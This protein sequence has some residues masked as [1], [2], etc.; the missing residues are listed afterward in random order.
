MITLKLSSLPKVFF[1]LGQT[2]SVSLL[3]PQLYLLSCVTLFDV[4][5]SWKRIPNKKLKVCLFVR[6]PQ[7]DATFDLTKDKRDSASANKLSS[8]SGSPGEKFDL[9]HFH[10]VCGGTKNFK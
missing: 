3:S 10:T 7:T 1:F 4:G 9:I 6:P 5:R 2:I 8:K